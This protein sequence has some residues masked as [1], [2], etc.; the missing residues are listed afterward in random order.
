MAGRS[1]RP[2]DSSAINKGLFEPRALAVIGASPHQGKVGYAL[3]ENII[4]SGYTGDIY[5][6][7]P[8][9]KEVQGLKA[10]PS[11]SE[12]PGAVDLAIVIVPAKAVPDVITGC[13]GK[14]IPFGV[15]ISAGFREVGIEGR[16]L[17]R[18]MVKRA[19]DGGMRI[20][21]PNCL[22][23][24]N[25]DLPLNASFSR[26]MAP[27][28][29]IGV[30]SQSGAILT[31]LLDWAVAE[32]VGFSKMI[33]LGNSADLVESDVIDA[34]AQDDET[35]MIAMYIEGVSDGGRFFKSLAAAYRRKPVV[36]LKAGTTQAGARAASSHTGA[37]AGSESAYA[38]V[39]EQAPAM[40][41]DS[42]EDLTELARAMAI[43]KEPAGP[44]LGIITN[45]GGP[46]II[47]SDMC[48]KEGLFLPQLS[49]AT[50][51]ALE[52]K[53]P[54]AASIHNPLDLLGD[55]DAQR[56]AAALEAL[57]ADNQ[58]HSIL[59]IL[60]PQAMTE[61]DRTAEEIVRIARGAD[62]TVMCSF[63]GAGSVEKA[64]GILQSGGIP[65][66]DFPDRA[67][68]VLGQMHTR[69][70][71]L[72]RPRSDPVQFE[73]N[74][75]L[76]KE[77]FDSYLEKGQNQ[78]GPEDCRR[79]LDAYGIKFAPFK[80]ATS[81]DRAKDIAQ[82]LGYPVALKIV[83]PQILH[84][85]DIGGVALDIKGRV[86]LED[87]F[88]QMMYKVRRS[89]PGAEIEGVGIQKMMPKGREL[90]LGLTKD[91]Q[92]GPLILVGLGGI[93]VELFQDV[94]FRLAPVTPGDATRMLRELKAFAL[95]EGI[96][97]EKRADIS[98]VEEVIMRLSQLSLEQEAL[99]EMDIN[100][101]MVYNSG[102][103]YTCVDV[104]M[105]LGGGRS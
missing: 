93:Y 58:M 52:G 54:A 34:L 86:E 98:S 24:M 30:I 71:Q 11:V 78:V 63:M 29:S 91:P 77:I 8:K 89:M 45:A 40:R 48:D 82:E 2:S 10:Y 56:F 15:V 22:G 7:N 88:D 13:T 39:C 60:T 41:A 55:A 95:L 66:I 35:T 51:K 69:T 19:R 102:V 42:V 79:V 97:G 18:D 81:F 47:A 87:S 43:Q 16:R 44:G 14:K 75:A 26:I 103:G 53:L 62:K 101:L 57:I 80:V 67:V 4:S 84:K 27:K 96:R 76:A 20:M 31:S 73:T 21:G 90:I 46:G 32:G 83:S 36:I 85:T 100:P 72:A 17:E 50:L 12:I 92:F 68:H 104:R 23:I 74:S 33:S 9:E 25:T 3:L 1:S 61:T 49:D 64:V 6:V 5:P 59:L 94:T 65:N 105:T 70:L 37:L 28:G 38:A 99:S